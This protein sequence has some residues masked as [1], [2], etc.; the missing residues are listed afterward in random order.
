[1]TFDPHAL[2]RNL[3]Q[4]LLRENRFE[5]LHWNYIHSVNDA[6]WVWERCMKTA[7]LWDECVDLEIVIEDLIAGARRAA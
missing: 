7:R 5:N 3:N 4:A 6:D 2:A 1:M